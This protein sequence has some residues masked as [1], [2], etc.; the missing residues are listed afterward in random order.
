M[1]SSFCLRQASC[2][3]CSGP[4]WPSAFPR[5]SALKASGD[6]CGVQ[7]LSSQTWNFAKNTWW[8]F[9]ESC[10]LAPPWKPK[11]FSS[12]KC[13]G[14]DLLKELPNHY[15]HS[16]QRYLIWTPLIRRDSN[17][18]KPFWRGHCSFWK[19]S[20]FLGPSNV[21]QGFE[22]PG[23]HYWKCEKVLLWMAESCQ[24]SQC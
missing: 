22:E 1:S 9:F 2:S 16:Q 12:W 17:I 5:A 14:M 6:H 19:V 23:F 3:C 18:N 13:P 11:D 21:S 7:L 4:G 24:Y 8:H 15:T 20:S 10:K